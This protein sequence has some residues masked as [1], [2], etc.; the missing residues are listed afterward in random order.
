MENKD[1]PLTSNQNENLITHQPQTNQQNID[2]NQFF[3]ENDNES[4]DNKYITISFLKYRVLVITLVIILLCVSIIP[5]SV[6]ENLDSII[7][8]ISIIP[9]VTVSL[10]M[11]L[12]SYNKL[13]ITKDKSNNKVIIK[14]KNFFCCPIKIIKIYLENFRFNFRTETDYDS[15]NG[16]S[17]KTI[18][19]IINDY[20][21][22]IDIDLDTSNIKKKPATFYY[23]FNNVRTIR[24][25]ENEY[26]YELNNF[27]G[28][29]GGNANM[30][31]NM[32]FSDHLF[33]Y[34]FRTPGSCSWVD[35]GILAT[36]F[37]SNFF[38]LSAVFSLLYEK[39]YV[40]IYIFVIWN[41]ILFII[42][43]CLKI[44]IDRIYRID[45]IYSR[46]F[47]RI[48]IG[49][50][51]Y[52]KTSYINTFES[53]INN[54]DKFILEK[55]GTD[56]YNLIAIFK[57]NER[58]LICNIKRARYSLGDLAFFINERLIKNKENLDVVT[59]N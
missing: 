22:L 42:Y 6:L 46:N 29:H 7:K 25:A 3:V 11:L 17:E 1:N 38:T 33:T 16:Y 19:T 4:S 14:V 43:K 23:T 9:G 13:V 40:G 44:F 15:E 18:F 54:L 51:K 55:K 47:D 59:T 8:Y 10:L 53:Q 27:L 12:F 5:V 31:K 26:T 48:F 28:I 52:N 41:I 35:I 58:Q 20:T 36:F 21:N 56:N 30:S 39:S 37:I 57:N 32:R 2:I 45:C 50:V 49:V 24:N 34:H